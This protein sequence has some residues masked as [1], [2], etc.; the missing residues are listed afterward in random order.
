MSELF[1]QINPNP[2]NFDIGLSL[3]MLKVFF[4]PNP[5]MGW[6]SMKLV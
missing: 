5:E 4:Q 3:K 6:V 2:E 1:Q